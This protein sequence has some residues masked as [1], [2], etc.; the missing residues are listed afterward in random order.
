MLRQAAQG[1][2]EILIVHGQVFRRAGDLLRRRENIQFAALFT[3]RDHITDPHLIG[4]N[5]DFLSVDK[6]MRV[7][8]Q[9]A[10]LI[11]GTGESGEIGR[12]SCRERVSDPV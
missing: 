4:R 1:G 10:G 9:L 11:D 12:A 3:N 7:T 2:R 5:I 8:D 6:E